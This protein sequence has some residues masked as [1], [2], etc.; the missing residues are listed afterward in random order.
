MAIIVVTF[1]SI[2]MKAVISTVGHTLRLLFQNAAE[3]YC[4]SVRWLGR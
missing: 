2:E 1:I 3:L 4:C